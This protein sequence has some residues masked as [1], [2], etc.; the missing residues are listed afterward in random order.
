MFSLW[1]F[2]FHCFI[3]GEELSNAFGKREVK[4]DRKKVAAVSQLSK[5][6]AE[7]QGKPNN[8]FLE[9]SKFDGEVQYV[10]K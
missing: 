5:Q 9:F 8:P 7:S 6:L 10:S 1:C 4:Q 2:F 3:Q